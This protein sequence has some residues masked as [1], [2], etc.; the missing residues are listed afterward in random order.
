MYD[1]VKRLNDTIADA[2]KKAKE[3][4]QAALKEA[5]LELFEVQP[6]LKGVYWT[7][8][9]PY[10]NDGEPCYFRVN[11]AYLSAEW[12][13]E[14]DAEHSSDDMHFEYPSTWKATDEEKATKEPVYKAVRE[15]FAAIPDE[16]MEATFGDHVEVIATRE[17][18]EVNDY[19]H[20]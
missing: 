1:W 9:T 15:L 19:S 12:T 18:F 7:Q 16:V 17:G 4:G 13:K 10:F 5:F 6:K 11:E 3:E 14:E 2:K 8:Y 20:D